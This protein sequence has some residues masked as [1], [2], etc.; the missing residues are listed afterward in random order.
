[1]MYVAVEPKLGSGD[2][3]SRFE[4]DWKLPACPTFLPSTDLSGPFSFF[5]FSLAC[6]CSYY[7]TVKGNEMSE[8]GLHGRLAGPGELPGDVCPPCRFFSDAC[9][10]SM[11]DTHTH[12][13]FQLLSPSQHV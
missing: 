2:W 13:G 6:I 1:M 7:Y 4:E 12:T 11:H 8:F 9:C 3:R 5:F 10:S